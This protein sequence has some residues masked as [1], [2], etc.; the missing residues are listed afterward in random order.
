MVTLVASIM[1]LSWLKKRGSMLIKY[2]G[3]SQGFER[4][5]SVGVLGNATRLSPH[6]AFGLPDFS[7]VQNLANK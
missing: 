2:R 7:A 5:A 6:S 1:I 4:N 3:L